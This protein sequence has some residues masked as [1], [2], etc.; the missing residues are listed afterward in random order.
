MTS[1]CPPWCVVD[2]GTQVGEEDAL[3]VSVTLSVRRTAVRLCLTRGEG[4]RTADGP[5]LLIGSDEY[6]LYEADALI[7]ALTQL[8]DAAGATRAGAGVVSPRA[9]A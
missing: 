9:G 2:H 8:V 6:T 4:F 5:Y 7:G 3:H 1:D